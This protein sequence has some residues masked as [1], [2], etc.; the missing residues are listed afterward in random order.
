MFQTTAMSLVPPRWRSALSI[1]NGRPVALTGP[2]QPRFNFEVTHV[3]TDDRELGALGDR[4][5]GDAFPHAGEPSLMLSRV[6][7][8]PARLVAF[9]SSGCIR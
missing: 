5:G 9:S 6:T 4:I 1:T 7:A 3:G 8:R 2:C